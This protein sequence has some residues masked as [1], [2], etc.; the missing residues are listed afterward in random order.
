MKG[1]LATGNHLHD[2]IGIAII[3]HPTLVELVHESLAAVAA[4]FTVVIAL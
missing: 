1:G 4:A 2:I 3:L